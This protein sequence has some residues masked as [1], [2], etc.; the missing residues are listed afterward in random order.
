MSGSKSLKCDIELVFLSEIDDYVRNKSK[1]GIVVFTKRADSWYRNFADYDKNLLVI[2]CSQE[3]R[4]KGI[5]E[6]NQAQK[7]LA[8]ET[9]IYMT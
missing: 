6:V 1:A 2:K 4:K 3:L 8:R 7:N 5:R 9:I